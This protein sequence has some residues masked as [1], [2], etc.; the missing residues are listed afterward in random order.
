MASR[1][2]EFA[3][4]CMSMTGYHGRQENEVT[5][6]SHRLF[7]TQSLRRPPNGLRFYCAASM[8]TRGASRKASASDLLR[9]SATPQLPHRQPLPST[10]T[11]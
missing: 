4:I 5:S 1:F 9:L 7:L 6:Q 2:T 8:V 11:Q 3:C 10:L